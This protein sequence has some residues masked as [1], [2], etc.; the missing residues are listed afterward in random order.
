MGSCAVPGPR[1]FLR[2]VRVGL[3]CRCTPR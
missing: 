3:S 1:R 2:R